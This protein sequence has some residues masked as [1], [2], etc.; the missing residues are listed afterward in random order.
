MRH[1]VIIGNGISGITAARH[2]RKRSDDRITVVSGE[3]DHF[4][5]RTALMYIYMGHMR[6]EHTKPYE[7]HFWAKNGIDLVRGWVERVDTTSRELELSDGR[8]I[9]WDVLL[10]ASGSRSNLFGWPGQDL[11][12]VQGLYGLQ[13]LERME[14]DT[15]GVRQAVVVG[16]GLIGVELAEMLHSRGIHVTFLVREPRFWGR[17]LPEAGS[18]IIERHLREHG[19]D[20]RLGTGLQELVDDG[21]GRVMAVR[22]T[23]GGEVP[24]GFVGIGVGVSP[25]IGFL[26]G[27]GI[28]TDRGVLVNGFLETNVRDVYAAGDC[29]QL[30]AH[31]EPGRPAIEAVWYTGRMMGEAVARTITGERTAYDPGPWFNS[32]KFFDIEYQTYGR[33]PAI[34]DEGHDAHTWE[35]PDGR[36]SLHLVWEKASRRFLGVNALGVRLRHEVFDAWL[37]QGASIDA[38]VAGLERAHF[39]PEFHRRYVRDLAQSFMPVVP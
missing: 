10:V 39:D 5:S 15:T 21:T 29:A 7:D 20:L 9:T 12:G 30:Q 34:L 3:S 35:H 26:Q 2:I 37:R 18:R 4:Y 36:R 24:A 14:R 23:T 19:I 17:V 25:N 22:T 33:V 8:W 16:G 6:H 11:R 13:D 31:P 27:S 32:A 1:I 38:V 28:S